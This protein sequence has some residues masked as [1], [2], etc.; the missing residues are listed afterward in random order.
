MSI[1]KVFAFLAIS[2]VCS[3]V[4]AEE[5]EPVPEQ[6]CTFRAAPSAFLDAQSRAHQTINS[7]LKDFRRSTAAPSNAEP[8]ERR[9]VIDFHVLGRLDELGVTPARLSTDQEFLRRVYLDVTGRIPSAPLVKAF[10]ASTD[11]N[12]RDNVIDALVSSPEF[13]DKWAVWIEDLL[14]ITER[15][16]TSGRAVQV[17]GRNAF[18]AWLRE[19]MS[20]NWSMTDIAKAVVTGSGNNYQFEN[21]PA[22]LM[23]ASSVGMGPI[24]DTYDMMLVKTTNA[25]LG[26]GHYDCLLCHNGRGHTEQLS[27]WATRTTRADAHRMAAHFSRVRL[28]SV[29]N[30]VQYQNPLYNSTNVTEAATGT[31]DLTTTFGNRP[32]RTPYGTERNLQPEYRDG[33]R[34][35]G[36]WREAFANKL[37]SDPLFA[38]N[39]TN[40]IWKEFFGLAMIDPVDAVDPDR[41]DPN[42]PPKAPWTLQAT[43]PELL[44]ALAEDFRR[45]GTSLRELVKVI[46]KSSAYQMSSQYDGE[47]KAQYVPLFA[48]HYPRRLWAEEVHDAIVQASGVTP[49]YSYLLVNN[50]TVAQGTPA[51]S[52]PKSEPTPWAMKMPDINEPRYL[53]GVTNG[54]AVTFMASFTRGNRDTVRRAGSGSILQQLSIMNDN[55]VVLSRLKI[56][57]SPNL[58]E[59]AKITDNAELVDEL[60][61]TFLSRRPTEAERAKAVA[62]LGKG[63][64]NTA[65]EDLA[66]VAVN[67]MD[68]LF[69]Y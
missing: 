56:G 54:G 62:H 44:Q 14:G 25:F 20:H 23:V 58:R 61:L 8:L 42:T 57:N 11:S 40:R 69:S 33:A 64:R 6:G 53:N 16:S 9:N 21:G 55:T 3:T 34:A 7:R 12:K 29:P 59:L 45:N 4:A 68:F 60:W 24:Q 30:A 63:N 38:I 32:N 41:L 1:A 15:L 31:Y 47:W 51:N 43:H 52:L 35:S 50:Q 67:K 13:N 5:S 66:W 22:N 26:L 28:S 37:T 17:E 36:N 65:I 2:F 27:S 49:Q 39:L 46:A 19:K 10:V 18:D 48:R